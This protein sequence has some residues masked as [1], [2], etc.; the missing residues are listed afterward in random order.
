MMT[1]I[2]SNQSMHVKKVP[3]HLKVKLTVKE[4]TEYSNIGINKLESP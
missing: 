3:I 2:S 1:I 4:A